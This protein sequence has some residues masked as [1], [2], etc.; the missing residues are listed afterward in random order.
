MIVSKIS[1]QQRYHVAVLDF[2]ADRIIVPVKEM[3]AD[4]LF[5]LRYQ[6][7]KH[8]KAKNALEEIKNQLKDTFVELE[9][10]GCDIFEATDIIKKVHQIMFKE[11]ENHWFFNI[12]SGNGLSANALSIA[13]MLH[14]DK[15]HSTKLYYYHYDHE[16]NKV[17]EQAMVDLPIF[18]IRTPSEKEIQILKLIGTRTDGITKKQLLELTEE[19][20]K[21][22]TPTEQSRLLMNLTRQVTD[23]LLYDWKM[24]TITGR[25]KNSQITLTEEGKHFI[26]YAN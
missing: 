1:G 4:K 10:V 18:K 11:P 12:S 6:D 9:E 5:L 16:A 3:K 23:K 2:R 8:T 25:G 17:K 15:I 26:R 14:K 13:A 22:K 19:T 20:Y 7:E 24:I 21:S